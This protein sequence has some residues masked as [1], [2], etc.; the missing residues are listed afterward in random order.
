M[1]DLSAHGESTGE[2][3]TLGLKEQFDVE[4]AVVYAREQHPD[5]P[6]ALIGISLGGAAALLASTL[7]IDALVLESVFPDV[8]TAVCNRCCDALGPLGM[9]PGWLLL[10]Q[11]EPRLGV[12]PSQL[13]PIDYVGRAGCPVMVLSGGEDR[14]TT[15][16]ETERLFD[17]APEPK[18][19]WIVP[20]AAHIDLHRFAPEEYE[21]RVQ[22]FLAE[23]LAG[24]D[25]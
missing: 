4:A 18:E 21:R 25:N 23:H 7:E 1:I 17:A 9:I 16:E 11:L 5:A 6:V 24:Q 3:I 14:H 20:G 10:A 15:V 2:Q 19:L 8:R 12:R 22:L 13:C